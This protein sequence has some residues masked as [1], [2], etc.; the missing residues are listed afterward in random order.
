MKPAP[1]HPSPPKSRGYAGRVLRWLVTLGLLVLVATQV[2]F[3]ALADVLRD[4]RWSWVGVAAAII[5]A[6][7][8]IATVRWWMLLRVKN[9]EIGLISLLNLH[10]AA[11]FMGGFLP[12]TFGVDAARIVLLSRRTGNTVQIVAASAADRLMMIV[13]TLV[14]AVLVSSF[15]VHAHFPMRLQWAIG[16]TG[17]AAL[18]GCVAVVVLGRMNFAGRASRAVLGE[19]ITGT[20]SHLYQSIWAY[21]H[22][23][24]VLW[25][26]F[27]I[28]VVLLALR[29]VILVAMAAAFDVDLSLSM[30]MVL[31]PM[32]ALVLMLPVS[33]GGFGLQEGAYVGL[34][35]LLGISATLAVSISLL[36][37]ML[38]RMVVLPGV[39]W[40]L[41]SGSQHAQLGDTGAVEA[42]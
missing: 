11:N 3:Q 13:A 29:G 8:V 36:D 24:G 14:A 9:I 22:N 28:S 20:L 15:F 4:I 5:F 21:R 34:L 25:Q 6:D 42:K 23:P 27:V 39:L 40:W 38:A 30:G 12:T 33:V 37:H 10:L 1:D 35:G 19:R 7:R 16:V 2:D 18:V 32:F 31:W 17:V 26:S 41:F